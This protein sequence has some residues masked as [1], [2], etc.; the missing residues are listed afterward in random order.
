MMPRP[1]G[2][3]VM[4]LLALAQTLFGAFRAVQ[5][6]E[7]GREQMERGIF[8]FPLAGMLM[9]VRGGLVVVIAL[10]Y[11]AFAIGAWARQA[12][13]W[14]LGLTAA[15]LNVTLVL[16]LVIDGAEITSALMT[17]LIPSVLACYLIA[18]AGRQAL[19]RRAAVT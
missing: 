3:T 15:C 17:A 6:F 18:P 19:T 1:V 12:W 5:W 9:I 10:L 2:L 8:V 13:S 4:I 11:L 14:W 7:L 16:W